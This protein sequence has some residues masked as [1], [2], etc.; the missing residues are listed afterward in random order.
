MQ[1]HDANNPNPERPPASAGFTSEVHREGV[2][3]RPKQT[4]FGQQPAILNAAPNAATLFRSLRRRLVL[5]ILLG[6]F[7]ATVVGAGVWSF[8]PPPK[9]NVRTLVD[10]PPDTFMFTIE[11]SAD[12]GS[13]Q[14]NQAALAK[15]RLVLNAALRDPSVA[16]LSVIANKLEPVEWLEQQVM[17]DFSV[18][19]TILKISMNGLE[20]ADLE[21]IVNAIRKAYLREIVDRQTTSRRVR[22]NFIGELLEKYEGQVKTS[23]EAQKAIEE[24]IGT[25]SADVRARTLVHAQNQLSMRE[26]DL[27]QKEM[28]LDRAKMKVE[29]LKVQEKNAHKMTVP[30]SMIEQALASHPEILKLTADISKTH[31]DRDDFKATAS[32]T[33]FAKE[34]PKFAARLTELKVKIQTIKTRERPEIKKKLEEQARLDL[35]TQMVVQESTIQNLQ[36]ALDML[37][38][39]VAKMREALADSTKKGLKLDTFKEDIGHVEDLTKKLKMD[40]EALKVELAAPSGVRVIEEATVTRSNT[41]QRQMMMVGGATIGSFFLVLFGVAWLEYRARRI[42]GVDEVV[43]GLGM[44]LVG[45]VPRAK[46]GNQTPDKNKTTS[47]ANQVLTESVDAARTTLLHLAR[48]QS[49]RTVMVTSA[50]AGEGKTSLSC[51]LAASLARAGLRTLLID[52]DMRNPKAHKLF[53]VPMGSGLSEV[54]TGKADLGACVKSTSV[55]GLY[56]LPAGMWNDLTLLA[57]NQGKA[58]AV[59]DQARQQYDIILV[60]SSPVLPVADALMIGQQVDGVLLSVLCG[61]SRLANLHAAWMR[62]EELGIRPLGVVING[63]QGGTYGSAYYYPY[64]RKPAAQS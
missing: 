58:M 51:H 32:E 44:R 8:A 43:F 15:S 37:K 7:I 39:M 9:H 55:R 24:Q 25:K 62:I 59:L 26:A 2:I 61:E 10:V 64:P 42:D 4:A 33:R 47:V 20:T 63:V 6:V 40:Q 14:R 30:E 54:L 11:R 50:V 16:N 52:G 38:P 5:A 18:A 53:G 57:L 31:K 56:L 46:K 12:Y 19:P 48:S 13:H 17:V 3:P 34:A 29:S 60:D 1:P 23:K 45:T 35:S 22:L 36:M 21:K 28:E 27:L 41:L 49:L